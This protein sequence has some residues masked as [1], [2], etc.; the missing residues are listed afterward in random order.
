MSGSTRKGGGAR[1]NKEAAK[2]KTLTKFQTFRGA[3]DETEE[4]RK[5]VDLRG[6][7]ASASSSLLIS[8]LGAAG[9]LSVLGLEKQHKRQP[10]VLCGT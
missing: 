6:T 2:D 5:A 10:S 8:Q 7:L 9:G 4:E 3:K 1:E